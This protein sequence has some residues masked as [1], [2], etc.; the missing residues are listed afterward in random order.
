VRLLP[1]ATLALVD[2][3][4]VYRTQRVLQFRFRVSVSAEMTRTNTYQHGQA[5]EVLCNFL[6]DERY[7]LVYIIQ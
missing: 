1:H 2:Q 5:I 6:R 3:L 7:D 4:L